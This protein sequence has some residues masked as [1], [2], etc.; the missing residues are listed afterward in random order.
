MPPRPSS[1]SNAYR[2]RSPSRSAATGSVTR[3]PPPASGTAGAC[4]ADRTSG[5]SGATPARGSTGSRAAARAG[6]APSP[7]R[8]RGCRSWRAVLQIG[9]GV[10]VAGGWQQRQ[11]AL[12]FPDRLRLPA[13]IGQREAERTMRRCGSSGVVGQGLLRAQTGRVGVDA[14]HG[15]VA[16][17]EVRLGPDDPPAAAVSVEGAGRQPQQQALLVVVEDPGQVPVV[18]EER[19]QRRGLHAG[20]S[21]GDHAARALEDHPEPR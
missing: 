8:R 3:C 14:R 1:R 20:W 4:A 18:G 9:A 7:A 5:R 10:A 11:A 15:R 12:A 17:E 16:S 2:S 19:D 6:P 13:H 21:V